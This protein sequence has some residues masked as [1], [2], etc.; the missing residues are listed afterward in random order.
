MSNYGPEAFDELKEIGT[1]CEGPGCTGTIVYEDDSFIELHI[2]EDTHLTHQVDW[3]FCSIKCMMTW[4]L[5]Q[6]ELIK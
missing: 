1:S 2:N 3:V 4:G 6:E 5:D